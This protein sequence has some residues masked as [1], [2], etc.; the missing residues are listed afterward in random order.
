MRE[1][2]FAGGEWKWAEIDFRSEESELQRVTADYKLPDKWLEQAGHEKRNNLQMNRNVEEKEA[3]WG[4]LIF[5]VKPADE[6]SQKIFR[7][8]LSEDILITDNPDFFSA[9]GLD[10]EL[11]Q[12]NMGAASTAVEGMMTIINEIIT[13]ILEQIDEMEKDIRELMWKLKKSNGEKVMKQLMSV[14]HQLLV[15]KNMIIPIQEIHMVIEEVFGEKVQDQDLYKKAGK[16]LDRCQYL[17]GQYSEEAATMV[18]F[19]EVIASV[20]G[21]EVMKTLTVITLLF[22]PIS[23][24]GAW[25]GMNFVYMPELDWQLGYL[26][27]GIFILINTVILFVFIK[28]KGWLGDLLNRKKN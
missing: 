10:K 9:A 28:K 15:L 13:G 17:I 6:D 5:G 4:S 18:N 22:T 16:Q 27:A 3:I 2:S 25:W 23:A 26:F 14:R 1:H 12:R 7:F 8:F 21:N 20:K 19:E 11:A 24:W